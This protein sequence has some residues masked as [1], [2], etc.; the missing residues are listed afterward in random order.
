MGEDRLPEGEVH[1]QQPVTVV[2]GDSPTLC[3]GMVMES[4]PPQCEGPTVT[5]WDL[6]NYEGTYVAHP[7][8]SWGDFLLRGVHDARANTFTVTEVE[9]HSPPSN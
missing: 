3:V 8:G 5:N 1:L 6:G 2:G 7:E 9:P 4:A